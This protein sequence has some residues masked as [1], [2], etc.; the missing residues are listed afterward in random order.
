MNHKVVSNLVDGYVEN[1]DN[2]K[3]LNKIIHKYIGD[4]FNK[5]CY[6][7]FTRY[8]PDNF[9]QCVISY[10][11]ELWMNPKNPSTFMYCKRCMRRCDYC[12]IW[13]QR[14]IVQICQDCGHYFCV[15]ESCAKHIAP[16]YSQGRKRQCLECSKK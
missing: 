16:H 10:K 3:N 6:G 13:G 2:E 9:V 4:H 7:C 15:Q 11:R 12:K 5:E 14:G 1:R 8:T